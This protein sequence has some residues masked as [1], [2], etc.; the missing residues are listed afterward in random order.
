MI[1]RP[2]ILKLLEANTGM[3]FKAQARQNLSEQNSNCVGICLRVSIWADINFKKFLY[4]KRDHQQ[5]K[6]TAHRMGKIFT[7]YMSD[8]RQTQNL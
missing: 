7:S 3:C 2:E 8:E 4:S 5:S 6:Q 1:L